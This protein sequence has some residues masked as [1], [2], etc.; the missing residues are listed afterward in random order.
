GAIGSFLMPPDGIPAP[1][2]ID[3]T[4]L[5]VSIYLDGTAITMDGKIVDDELKE[6]AARLGK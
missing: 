4:C 5:S 3:A 2:H 1:S 6:Y